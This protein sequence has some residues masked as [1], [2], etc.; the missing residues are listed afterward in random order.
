MAYC[1]ALQK[2]QLYCTDVPR[3]QGIAERNRDQGIEGRD[4]SFPHLWD[5]IQI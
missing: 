4:F 2:T 3:V 5:Q 1:L